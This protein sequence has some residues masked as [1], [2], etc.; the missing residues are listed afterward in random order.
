MDL[1][2]HSVLMM[3]PNEIK[4]AEELHDKLKQRIIKQYKILVG[5]ALELEIEVH[6]GIDY[7][8]ESY[9]DFVYRYLLLGKLLEFTKE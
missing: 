5:K 6:K 8:D 4:L 2:E 7:M 9:N 3:L 1:K